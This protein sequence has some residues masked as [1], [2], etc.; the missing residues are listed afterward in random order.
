MALVAEKD[1]VRWAAQRQFPIIPCTLCGS[2]TNLQRVQVGQMLRDWEKSHP[3]RI[4]S[5]FSALQNVVPSHLMDGTRYDF[6]GLKPDGLANVDG[7]KAFDGD[8][9]ATAGAPALQVVRFGN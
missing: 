5:M 1:L 9:L 7:D 4:E 3:G 8:D 2:Q 6:K